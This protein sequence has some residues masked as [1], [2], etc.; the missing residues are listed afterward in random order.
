RAVGADVTIFERMTGGGGTTA[1]AGGHIYLGGGTPVQEASGFTD[2]ADDMYAYLTAVSR[3]PDP[4]K[5]RAYCDGSVAHFTWLEAHGIRFDRTYLPGK[6]L[7]QYG[8]DCLVWTGNETVWPFRDMARP[9]PRGHKPAVAG[10]AGA[11]IVEALT[12]SAVAAGANLETETRV[13][14][15]RQDQRSRVVGV[16][17]ERDGE[18]MDVDARGGV[19]LAA[20][21]FT[22]NSEM[23]AQYVPV[24]AS[25]EPLGSPADDGAAITLGTGV[26]GAV[27][28]M[29]GAFL[30]ATH[31][32]PSGMLKGVIVNSEG[33]RFVAED[34]YHG[35]TGSF[36]AAQPGRVAYLIL[37]DATFVRP[38]LDT[39][40]FIDGWENVADMERALGM[41]SGSLEKTVAYYNRHAAEGLDP[42]FGKAAEWLQPLH[43]P[44]AAFDMSIGKAR[45]CGFTLG[46]LV[47]SVD[48][49]V[50]DD[51]G[52]SIHGLYAAGAC[53]SNLV[54][55]GP[56]YNSGLS[57]GEATFFGRSAGR[58][59]ARTAV[60]GPAQG[61]RG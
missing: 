40:P 33:N 28:H 32:P 58:H 45:Y 61:D 1:L 10:D 24:L 9:A 29:D 48:G 55:D 39:L 52:Q 38:R 6:H 44:F 50:L 51:L 12:A 60:G 31:Y 59:A 46:G 27:A 17:I 43:P 2:T 22:M 5:I 14:A 21:G 30:S 36:V 47:T 49:E 23:I 11:V 34:S 18:R 3:E 42:T 57:I 35:R 19:I 16:T 41:T 25:A 37:D 15:L 26:G 13:V 56:S 54:Q 53:A 20:G 4:L 7:F 8:P